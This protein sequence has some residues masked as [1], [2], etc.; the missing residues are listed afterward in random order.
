MLR[1]FLLFML[2]VLGLGSAARATKVYADLSAST[3]VGNATWDATA[4]VFAWTQSAYAYMELAGFPA[5]LSG[6]TQLVVVTEDPTPGNADDT[7]S[8]RIDFDLGNNNVVKGSEI[9][10]AYWSYGTKTINLTE[11]LT[12]EQLASVQRVRLSTN[13]NEGS[14]ILKETYLV[15]PTVFDFDDNGCA[16][17]YPGDFEYTGGLSYNPVTQELTN[18]GTEGGTMSI[19]FPLEG[20][21]FSHVVRVWSEVDNTT[22]GYSQVLSNCNIFQPDGT[23][24]G[25]GWYSTLFDINYNAYQTSGA[26]VGSISFYGN[27]TAGKMKFSRII[28]KKDMLYA[29]SGGESNLQ[30]EPYYE[31]AGEEWVK[32][33]ATYNLGI[34]TET[35]YGDGNSTPNRYID[36]SAYDELRVY[37]SEGNPVRAFFLNPNGDSKIVS[38]SNPES[39]MAY[40][41]FDLKSIKDELGVAK[42]IGVKTQYGQKAIVQQLVLYK[43][44][45]TDIDY[46]LYGEGDYTAS[47]TAAFNDVMAKVIDASGLTENT[48]LSSANPNC[49]FLVSDASKLSNEKNVLVKGEDGTYACANLALESGYSFRT[50]YSFTVEAAS[51]KKTVGPNFGTFVSPFEVDVPDGCKAYNL[52]GVDENNV[53]TGEETA[54]V[55]A[56]KPVLLA[57]DG[58]CTFEAEDVTVEAAPASL[59]NGILNGVYEAGTTAPEGSYVLQTQDDVTAFYK[60][61]EGGKQR[62]TPFTAYLA[63]PTAAAVNAK[64]LSVSFDNAGT[65]RVDDAA[66][67]GPATVEAVYDLQGRK[68]DAPT[69]GV[70]L[71]RLSDGSV[72][73]VIVK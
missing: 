39:G 13:S 6:Y 33:D 20:I 10:A 45:G 3:A 16:V 43:A 15:K 72:K 32:K 11:K 55:A 28:I 68:L 58:E 54:T 52:T 62:V 26:T 46:V 63:L 23:P 18:D 49:L 9:G 12:P 17:L 64:S 73:K 37:M 8:Y 44:S 4:G 14:V 35:V 47:A 29:Y 25:S 60:V 48:E 59:V 34:V 71:L 24:V 56:N 69:K 51:V 53:V 1:R 42:L 21:D 70:N 31:K 40:C 66:A 67:E 36:I 7:N 5:G 50:P 41:K 61:A 22:S 38:A 19:A 65:T 30:A 2:V 27:S 57:G